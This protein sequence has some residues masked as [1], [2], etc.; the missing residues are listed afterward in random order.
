MKVKLLK[1]IIE[2]DR[3]GESVGVKTS[4][5]KNKAFGPPQVVYGKLVECSDPEFI[6]TTWTAGTVIEMSEA[7]AAKYVEAGNGEYVK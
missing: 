2:Y 6:T 1:D 7:S 5:R 3:H 4:R